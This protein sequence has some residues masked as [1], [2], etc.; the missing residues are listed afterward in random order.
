MNRNKLVREQLEASLQRLAPLRGIN[1]PSK[2]WVRAIRDAL[3]MTA[4]QLA[5]RLGVSQQS[6]T[7][8][9]NHELS[10][11]V[12]IKTM[13]RVAEGLDCVFVCGFVPKSSLEATLRKQAERLAS[14]RLARASQT[15]ALEDQGLSAGEN[16]KV[17]SEMVDEIV[18]ELP[19][20]LWSEH[21]GI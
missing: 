21:D 10:G 18:D 19:S 14:G 4:R 13:R 9:E 20:N 15:M 1:P 11:A 17:L 7:R 2:G 16:K 3:G 12:T 5:G 8:I 6:V